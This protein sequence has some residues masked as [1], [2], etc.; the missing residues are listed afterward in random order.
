MIK[1]YL[2]HVKTYCNLKFKNCIAKFL[3][4]RT[5]LYLLFLFIQYITISFS[6]KFM[7]PSYLIFYK[8]SKLEMRGK[9]KDK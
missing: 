2:S 1:L 6:Q 7:F 3:I 8:V 9:N 4:Y 5:K